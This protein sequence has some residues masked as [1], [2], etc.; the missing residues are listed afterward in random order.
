MIHRF[1]II[2]IQRLVLVEINIQFQSNN[3]LI[4]VDFV[5]FA[6]FMEKKINYRVF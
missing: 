3:T 2:G 1:S 4:I 5:N 6:L